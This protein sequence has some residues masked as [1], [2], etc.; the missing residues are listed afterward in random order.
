MYVIK[1]DY[2]VKWIR[3]EQGGERPTDSPFHVTGQTLIRVRFL[4]CVQFQML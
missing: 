2:T 1:D 3:R 4:F